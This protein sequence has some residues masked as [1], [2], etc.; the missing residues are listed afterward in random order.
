M[1]EKWKERRE[2]ARRDGKK[3]EFTFEVNPGEVWEEDEFW[4]ELSWRI[5]KKGDLGI[6]KHFLSPYRKNEKINVDE[7]YQY[8][9]EKTKG[10]PEYSFSGFNPMNLPP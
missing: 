7:Y 9:F 5:D 10:L 1:R 8:I 6:R 4:I 2:K 3:V